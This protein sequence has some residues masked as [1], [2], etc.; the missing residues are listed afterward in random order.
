MFRGLLKELY[1][2]RK[3]MEI[4]LFEG[5]SHILANHVLLNNIGSQRDPIVSFLWGSGFYL[6]PNT[7]EIVGYISIAYGLIRV[8][9]GS[10]T[11]SVSH[12]CSVEGMGPD[13][14]GVLKKEDF[15]NCVGFVRDSSTSR[16]ISSSFDSF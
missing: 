9:Y 5:E 14:L 13:P 2:T 15:I 1:Q 4:P 7:D 6:F 11:V 12:S 8:T 10:C 3:A 16:I